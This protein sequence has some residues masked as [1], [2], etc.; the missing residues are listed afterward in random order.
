MLFIIYLFNCK[1]RPLVRVVI[2]KNT[3]TIP[4]EHWGL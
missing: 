4:Y 3:L 1:T 2:I